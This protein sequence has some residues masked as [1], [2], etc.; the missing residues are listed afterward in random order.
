MDNFASLPPEVL[1]QVF[2]F[3]DVVDL[4]TLLTRVCK[5]VHSETSRGK[6]YR[7]AYPQTSEDPLSPVSPNSF[8]TSVITFD[9]VW[10]RL[11][12][13][14]PR[15]STT[16]QRRSQRIAAIPNC[17][18]FLT[19]ID[20]YVMALESTFT[21][22]ISILK[23]STSPRSIKSQVGAAVAQ[24]CS[25]FADYP[26]FHGFPSCHRS[27]TYGQSTVFHILAARGLPSLNN[28]AGFTNAI[29]ATMKLFLSG[30]DELRCVHHCA[31]KGNHKLLDA[32][33]KMWQ[34]QN[35]GRRNGA[36]FSEATYGA[37]GL[38]GG[39][40]RYKHALQGPGNPETWARHY[41]DFNQTLLRHGP[42]PSKAAEIVV[43]TTVLDKT[44][45]VLAEVKGRQAD[46]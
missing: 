15:N 16:S 38:G 39:V 23:G 24:F 13:A 5:G 42:D 36:L 11:L 35:P 45:E 8:Y 31:V 25:R 43:R 28:D 21:D 37:G 40:V 27:I 7:L 2:L 9:C 44:L 34:E 20:T 1:C 19:D 4:V 22:I 6:I 26:W 10:E 30:S 29:I 12:K 18:K 14:G 32:M 17:I 46:A 41:H 33:D 3:I